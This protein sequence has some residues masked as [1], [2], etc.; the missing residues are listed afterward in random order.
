M[1]AWIAV[2][3]TFVLGLSLSAQT[4]LPDQFAAKFQRDL[5]TLASTANGVVGV[6]VVDLTTNRRFDVNGVT[7]FPQGSAIKV[8]LLIELFRQADAKSLSLAERVTLTA[9]DR[10]GGSS[11]LQYFSD[12]G[13]AFSLHDLTVP[14]VVLSDNTATNMLIDNVGMDKVNAHMAS[15]GFANTKLR[16]KMIRQ[17]EQAKG[18][19]NISTP[20]EAVDVMARLSRCDVGLTPA[21]CAEVIRLLELPKD[22]A[23]RDPIPAS[24]PVAWK[25]GS[26]DGVSTAWGI[27][28]LE[29]AP[30]AIAAMVT[31]GDAQVDD[32]VRRISAA[33]YAHFTQLAGATAL[34]ARIDPT[35]LKKPGAK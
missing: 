28:R 17:A 4:S 27:V 23:F 19:E 13:S 35:L 10:T 21:S 7:V 29:G 14:M 25:P 16:R 18:N 2:A 12:G 34:G 8:P 3:A 6:S 22:G 32:V 11:L 30:Y 26:L 24:V 31:Y 33:T 15:L 1:R 9:A 5:E 20:R